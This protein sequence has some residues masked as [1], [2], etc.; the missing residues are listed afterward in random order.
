MRRE[1]RIKR[2]RMHRFFYNIGII[3]A[4]LIILLIVLY[5]IYNNN[6]NN[7]S[8]SMLSK[9][10][11]ISMGPAYKNDTE[12][13][14]AVLSK[15][16]EEAKEEN[17][18]RIE[19]IENINNMDNEEPAMEIIEE[20]IITNEVVEE[21]PKVETKK[22]LSFEYPVQGD[23]IREYAMENLVYSETLEEWTIHQGID[24]KADRTT[25][26]KAAEEGVVTA[27]KN[28]PRFG[29]TIIIE[30]QDGFKT[31]YSN[32]L[33]TEFVSED[34]HVVKG[35]TIGTVGNSAAF[36]IADEPHLHFE[37]IKDGEYINPLNY[38]K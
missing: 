1:R 7:I 37:I 29:L 36:E 33:T 19:D 22:E 10:E 9:E 23:I 38:I 3:I 27:I 25:V 26:V 24:I 21:E 32:L 14:G 2:I 31:V 8:K 5:K 34:E 20:G 30:H 16:I 4:F 18:S 35:Q 17:E 12:S 11:I 15:T 13:A 6:L 28:D